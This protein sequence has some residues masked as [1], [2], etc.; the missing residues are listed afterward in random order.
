LDLIHNQQN[1]YLNNIN[2]S[3]IGNLTD[4]SFE[5]TY[6]SGANTY[7]LYYIPADNADYSIKFFEKNILTAQS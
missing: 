5:T 7:V 4:L 6:D 2:Y 1:S 3:V